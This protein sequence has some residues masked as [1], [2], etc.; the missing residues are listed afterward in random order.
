MGRLRQTAAGGCNHL[1]HYD[2]N[3]ND[4]YDDDHNH[5]DHHDH[6]DDHHNYDDDHNEHNDDDHNYNNHHNLWFVRRSAQHVVRMKTE[7][8]QLTRK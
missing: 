1:N 7:C 3:H 8:T 2:D 4:H 5:H 6:H